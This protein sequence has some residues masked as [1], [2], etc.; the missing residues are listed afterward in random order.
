M[1]KSLL[2]WQEFL[3]PRIEPKDQKLEP[4]IVFDDKNNSHLILFS[5]WKAN[6]KVHS[7]LI[8]IKIIEN[9]IWV[10]ENNTEEGIAADLEKYGVAKSDIV[11]GFQPPNVRPF[12][13]YASTQ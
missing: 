2:E 12:T 7:L 6:Q 10:Q 13:E 9:K 4:K 3:T 11:L 1:K 5:G 8:Y